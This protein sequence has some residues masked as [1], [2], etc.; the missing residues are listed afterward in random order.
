[1]DKLTDKFIRADKPLD[2]EKIEELARITTAD[3]S[4][5]YDR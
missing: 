4:P 2:L 3:H 5:H 1:M